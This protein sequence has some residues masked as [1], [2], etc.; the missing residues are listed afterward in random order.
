MTEFPFP[1]FCTDAA[2]ILDG[3]KPGSILSHVTFLLR[4]FKHFFTAFSISIS[5]LVATFDKGRENF[6]PYFSRFLYQIPF[7]IPY[8]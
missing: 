2:A 7:I 5:H 1:E 4:D 6:I 3:E 8:S